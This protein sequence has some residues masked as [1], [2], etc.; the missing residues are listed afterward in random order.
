M[1][2]V[3]CVLFY[4]N[5]VVLGPPGS[6][7]GTQ[8]ELLAKKYNLEHIDMGKYLREVAKLNTPLGRKI[9]EIINVQR[10]PV[11]ADI[12]KKVL[13]VKIQDIPREQGIVFDGV[14]RKKDQ[15]KY[16]EEAMKEFGRKVDAVVYINISEDESIDRVSR[17][18]TCKKNEHVLIMGKDIQSDKDKCPIC[19]SEIFQRMDQTIEATKKR[20]GW[21]R[22]ETLPVI[23]YFRK[24]GILIEVDGAPTIEEV[25]NDI[26]NKLKGIPG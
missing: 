11:D 4:M 5:I 17:R 2:C 3:K 1:L 22:E 9:H 18:W 8:A 6:G 13:H 7:K 12:L 23:E 26:L 25:Q 16:F 15:L 20:Y 14:P 19:G 21:F 10:L 24:K